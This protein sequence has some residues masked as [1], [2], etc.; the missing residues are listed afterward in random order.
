[1]SI[2]PQYGATKLPE[3]V[4]PSAATSTLPSA[5]ASG[6]LSHARAQLDAVSRSMPIDSQRGRRRFCE[7]MRRLHAGNLA[8]QD[9]VVPT[10]F[11]FG[12]GSI[13]HG[14]KLRRGDGKGYARGAAS[15]CCSVE[16]NRV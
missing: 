5:L 1:M 10:T 13:G 8:E 4:K 12:F 11:E 9:V 16:V 14:G 2:Q 6:D 7:R 15:G 3:I